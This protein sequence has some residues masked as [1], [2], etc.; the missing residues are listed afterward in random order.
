MRTIFQVLSVLVAFAT[1]APT[2]MAQELVLY[3]GR[4]KSL[5]QPIVRQF[6]RETGIK[7]QVRYGETAQ[8]AIALQEEG[9][10]SRADVFWAQD[11]GALGATVDAGLFTVLPES[12][13]QRVPAAYHSPD[14]YWVAT[15]G[16]VRTLAYSPKRVD[17]SELPTSVFDLTQPQ[18]KGRVGWAP[19]NAS[20]QAFVTAIRKTHGEDKARQWLQGMIANNTRAYPNNTSIVQGIAAG[21]VDFGLPNHY[22][23]LRFKTADKNYPVEQTSFAAGDVG[24]LINVAGVGILTSATHRNEAQKFLTFLLSPAAQ[25][26]FASET[27]EYPVTDDVIPSTKLPDPETLHDRAPQVD[28]DSLHDLEGTLKLFREVGLL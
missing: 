12:I 7:V 3:A 24:N 16:R 6:E 8:L 2:V 15:S 4:S 10:R 18:Y 27:F 23:L 9:A 17:K 14:N 19:T 5:V 1:L 26:Y 28:L 25:Q 11:A 13:I 21:E 20:F 22:Y